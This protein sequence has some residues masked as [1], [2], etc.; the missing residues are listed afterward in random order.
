MWSELL[1]K[2]KALLEANTKIQEVYDYEAEEF[3]GL[4]SVTITPSDNSNDYYTTS[5]NVRVYAFNVRLFVSRTGKTPQEADRIMR[6]LVDT[7]LDDFDKNWNLPG[8]VNPTGYTFI[9][10]FAIPS[11]WGYSGQREDEFRAA[12]IRVQCRV[13]VDTTNIT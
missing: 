2:I 13:V 11:T 4:P 12:E 3:K 5:E 1:S 9:N 6:N 8:V 10:M 7:V